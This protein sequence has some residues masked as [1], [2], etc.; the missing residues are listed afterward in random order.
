MTDGLGQSL[1]TCRH[2]SWPREGYGLEL[3]MVKASNW[4]SLQLLKISYSLCSQSW[5]GMR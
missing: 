4:I 3:D 5:K 1:G 2:C